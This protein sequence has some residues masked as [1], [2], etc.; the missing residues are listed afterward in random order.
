[1]KFNSQ[2]ISAGSGSIGGCTFSRNRFGQYVRRRSVPVNPGSVY[3]NLITAALGTLVA[4]WKTLTTVVRDN[5]TN[6]A[7]NTPHTDALGNPIILTGQQMYVSCNTLR[8]QVPTTILDTAPIIFGMATLTPPAL[9]SLIAATN[10]L[11]FTFTNTDPW[12]IAVGGYLMVYSSRPQS[13]TTYFFKG[14]YRYATNVPGAVV[15]PTSPGTCTSPFDYGVGQRGH[16]QFRAI[17][18]DGRI[19]PVVRLAALAT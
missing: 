2:I 19:S 6:Y 18:A 5:W 10:I 3:Q 16:F 17:N 12:A 4:R 8:L 11:T 1:M 15:P 14:P 9:T 7:L 13:P